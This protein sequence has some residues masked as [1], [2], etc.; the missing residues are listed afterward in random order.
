MILADTNASAIEIK[1]PLPI[2]IDS[3][4]GAWCEPGTFTINVVATGSWTV[5]FINEADAIPERGPTGTPSVKTRFTQI[6]TGRDHTCG[7]TTSGSVTCWG[8]NA[9]GKATPPEGEFVHV[10]AGESHTCGLTIEGTVRCWGDGYYGQTGVPDDEFVQATSSCA[11]RADGSFVCWGRFGVLESP[12][13]VRVVELADV[14]IEQF[15]DGS[16]CGLRAD[17]SVICWYERGRFGETPSLVAVEDFVTGTFIHLGNRCGTRTDGSVT[18][19]YARSPDPTHPPGDDAFTSTS[20]LCGITIDE[21]IRCWGTGQYGRANRPDEA[22]EGNYT[23][24]AGGSF[25]ACA[26]AVGGSV[27]CWGEGYEATPPPIDPEFASVSVGNPHACG[28][29]VEGELRCWGYD[30]RGAA[31]AVEGWRAPAFGGLPAGE[32]TQVSVGIGG[33]D[34]LSCAVRV[35]GSVACWDYFGP[36]ERQRAAGRDAAG[37]SVGTQ[38]VCVWFSDGGADC[39]RKPEYEVD[40]SAGVPVLCVSFSNGGVKCSP[41]SKD[42]IAESF[43]SSEALSD[44]SAGWGRACGVRSNGTLRCWGGENNWPEDPQGSDFVQV[45]GGIQQM[46]A[47][48]ADN[49]LHC[50]HLLTRA[51]AEADLPIPEDPPSGAY[52]QVSMG[53]NFGCAVR[54]DGGIDCWDAGMLGR[55]GP[56][57]GP[58]V[59]VAVGYD[60]ACGV[61]PSGRIEC[62]A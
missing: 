26:I 47:I 21:E 36:E 45:S 43:S 44:M 56:P 15:G 9:Y 28:I 52:S 40:T 17:N 58:F 37:V 38:L 32:F 41:D 42:S 7:V 8:R 19:W 4:P 20:D 18:C 39:S 61:R 35:D 59:Q 22:P 29:T 1:S 34:D 12:P 2:V 30:F 31:P 50:W 24:V 60:Y 57:S 6:S 48:R 51:L 16:W 25:H 53:A 49:R 5:T 14:H 62:W 10:S 54:V 55:S 23:Q 33:W 46:C 11:L 3:G 13:E 27:R